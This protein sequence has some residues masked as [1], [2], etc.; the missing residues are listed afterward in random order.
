MQENRREKMDLFDKTTRAVREI[1]NATREQTELAN[2][3]IQ[4]AAIEKKL[5]SQYAEIGKRYVAYIAD[6]FRTEPFDVTDILDVIN[7]D[8][9]K[10][11]E[12]VDQVEQKEQQFRQHS[13]E[14]DRKR[15]LEQFENEKR[16]LDKA[17]DLEIISDLEYSEKLAKARKKFDN[18]EM[19]KK[20]QMQLEMDIITR[21]E[22]EEKVQNI[23]Q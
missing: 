6:T 14:K 3:K 5:E 23:L 20:I 7:P 8:L 17:K 12:I 19:L 2:L 15:A 10:I 16:K 1:G 22:Y 13:I 11:T 4:K 18:F 9:E 21:E